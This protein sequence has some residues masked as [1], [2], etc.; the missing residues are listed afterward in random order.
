MKSKKEIRQD[1]RTAKCSTRMDYEEV[2]LELL[3]DI[4]ELFS[5]RYEK[6]IKVCPHEEYCMIRYDGDCLST[7]DVWNDC[8]AY[9][10]L[11]AL[12]DREQIQVRRAKYAFE[13]TRT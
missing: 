10:T 6:M 5:Y 3:L 1:I 9:R 7:G 2:M 11:E 13:E 4:G 12:L 8:W